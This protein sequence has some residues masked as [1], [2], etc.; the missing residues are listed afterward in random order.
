MP[1]PLDSLG[2]EASLTPSSSRHSFNL[3]HILG[4]LILAV[5][6]GTLLSAAY[7]MKT[8][9]SVVPYWDELDELISYVDAMHGSVLSWIWT[10]HNEHR[11]LFYKLFFIVDIQFFKD[12]N[13]PMYLAIFGSQ[14]ALAVVFG[15]MLHQL[16]DL[17]GRLW[18]ACFGLTLYC[19]FC[20]SQWEN[21][22][23][24]FQISFVLVNLWVTMAILCL[25]IHKQ[26]LAAGQ[27]AGMG[28]VLVS[29]AA[30]TAA[31]F[32]N[33]NGIV[34]WPVLITVALLSQLPWRTVGVYTFGLVC[35]P[36]YLIGYHSPRYHASPLQSLHQPQLII[37]YIL[38][39]IGGGA[40]PDRHIGLAPVV[41][42]F[43]LATA[44][45]LIFGLMMH[46]EK[47]GL[48]EYVFAGIILYIVATAFIT[49]LGRMNFGVNQAF[50]S[51][52]QSFALLFWLSLSLW[53]ISI[54]ARQQK[55][56][57]LITMYLVIMVTACYS[58]TGYAHIIDRVRQNTA[59]REFAGV[60]IITGVHDEGFLE[61]AI[62]PSPIRWPEVEQLRALHLSLFSTSRAAQFG[63]DFGQLFRVVNSEE[64][65][66][67][68]EVPS[69]VDA[70]AEGASI[71]G[72]VVERR[73]GKPLQEVVFV[74]DRKIVG[75]GAADAGGIVAVDLPHVDRALHTGWIGYA[76]LSGS[77]TIDVY[78][79]LNS[80]G[81]NDGCHFG[82]VS[83]DSF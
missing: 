52:Y 10:Q 79:V 17:R 19:L 69:H 26:R 9:Y 30:A 81:H 21:F 27:P 54:A 83:S 56:N 18:Q 77:T 60:G 44:V 73:T 8:G 42:L 29:L 40:V 25:V 31:T 64:C 5:G 16:A 15:Y 68:V 37:Q 43:G 22:S 62:L 72:W 51:R 63:Q 55:T 80:S 4:S 6:A 58:A 34:V 75:F 23:W 49:S 50:S 66:G 38:S 12:R 78:A 36:L 32:T 3:I 48:L 67:N 82:A 1:T 61:A 39:Y 14:V 46:R 65:E 74:A 24:A 41:G 35:V 7:L 57:W 11:I 59:R 33:G 71:R 47:A 70:N 2:Q 76:R 28:V 20:P 45:V 53:I 13:W